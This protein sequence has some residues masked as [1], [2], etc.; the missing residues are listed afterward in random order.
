MSSG[1][2][3]PDLLLEKVRGETECCI[4][5]EVY[6]DPRI[7]PCYHTFCLKCLSTDAALRNDPGQ[8]LSCSICRKEYAIPAAGLAALP[9][10]FSMMRLIEMLHAQRVHSA[11]GPPGDLC[12]SCLEATDPEL[13]VSVPCAEMF[14]A[15]CQQKL[16]EKCTVYHRKNKMT[17]LHTV[18]PVGSQ[19]RQTLVPKFRPEICDIHKK[20][21]LL[22]CEDCDVTICPLCFVEKHNFHKILDAQKLVTDFSTKI[23]DEASVLSKY[24]VE[25]EETRKKVLVAA[26]NFI[27]QVRSV[28]Q[29]ITERGKEMKELID[30]HV[31]MITTDMTS[32]GTLHF[33]EFK[34]Q[35]DELNKHTSEIQSTLHYYSNVTPISAKELSVMLGKVNKAVSKLKEKHAVQITQNISVTDIIFDIEDLNFYFSGQRN[36]VGKIEG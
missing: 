11:G 35:V 20:E 22:F 31:S 25:V 4:C 7:L 36:I 28:K 29:Q 15:D 21:R 33:K 24:L 12:D 10:N 17:K 18:V 1:D 30:K 32:L 6:S 16:C 13:H 3:N 5:I 9:K 34:S 23:K 19:P 2:Q 14:C 26:R 27:T 8:K